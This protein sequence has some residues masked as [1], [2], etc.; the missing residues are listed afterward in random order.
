MEEFFTLFTTEQSDIL[1]TKSDYK[2]WLNIVKE[3][4]KLPLDKI[5]SDAEIAEVNNMLGIK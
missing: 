4:N 2:S 1:K 3:K 5:N